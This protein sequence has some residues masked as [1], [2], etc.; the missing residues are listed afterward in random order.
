[1]GVANSSQ[2]KSGES[3]SLG[4]WITYFNG[5]MFGATVVGV[6]EVLAGCCDG[7]PS[8]SQGYHVI[9]SKG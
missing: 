7:H 6:G 2:R 4:T 1:M 8:I 3:W 5:E 9:T